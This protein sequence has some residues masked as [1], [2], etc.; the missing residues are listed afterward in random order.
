MPEAPRRTCV[1]CRTGRTKAELL[2]LARTPEGVRYDRDKRLP[3]RGA[4][5]CP[6][7]RCFEA[8]ARR[9]AQ[10]VRRA[11]RG[12]PE[13]EVV[14]ALADARRDVGTDAAPPEE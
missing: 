4:Y 14:E 1:G 13:D 12:A 2:R 8:A 7:P 6:D 5:V 9:G 11:L 10:A 3:G